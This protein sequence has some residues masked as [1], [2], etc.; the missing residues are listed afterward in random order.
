MSVAGATNDPPDCRHL[1]PMP[2]RTT[3][4]RLRKKGEARFVLMMALWRFIRHGDGPAD[5]WWEAW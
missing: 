1:L 5:Y 2:H 3:F 4:L